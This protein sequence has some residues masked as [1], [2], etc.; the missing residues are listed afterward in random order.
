MR[1][2]ASVRHG[3]SVTPGVA[4]GDVALHRGVAQ[5]PD[6][7]ASAEVSMQPNLMVECDAALA[8][9]VMK[10]VEP[11]EDH[12]DVQKVFHNAD[13]AEEVLAKLS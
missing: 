7:L 13:I 4:G 9:R 3:L 6:E 8:A 12:D 2:T 10:L 5:A 1:V 11:L